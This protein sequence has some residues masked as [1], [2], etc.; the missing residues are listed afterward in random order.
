MSQYLPLKLCNEQFPQ[1]QKNESRDEMYST[2]ERAKEY[3]SPSTSGGRV[4]TIPQM[5]AVVAYTSSMRDSYNSICKLYALFMAPYSSEIKIDAVLLK[6]R[7]R[8]QRFFKYREDALFCF[9]IHKC[10]Q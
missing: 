1:T 9:I 8:L 7:K 4:E 3:T 6:V 10:L 5:L 2:G